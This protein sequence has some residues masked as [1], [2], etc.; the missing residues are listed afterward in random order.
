MRH[1]VTIS[2]LLGLLSSLSFGQDDQRAILHVTS[3]R[4]EEAKDWCTAG[5][6]SATRFTVE[7]FIKTGDDA[8]VEY[9]LE[10]IEVLAHKPSPHLKFE[11]VRVHA[12]DDYVVKV[13]S[14]SGAIAFQHEKQNQSSSSTEMAYDI[15]SERE[16]IKKKSK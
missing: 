4:K 12:H 15:L 13:F 2:L 14:G 3:V 10:C 1:L 16:V 6:C 11:C 7:G 8:S 5:E 9:V